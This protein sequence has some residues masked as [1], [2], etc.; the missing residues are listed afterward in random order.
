M[1][2]QLG[3]SR[4]KDGN[5]VACEFTSSAGRQDS[6]PGLLAHRWREFFAGPRLQP[7]PALAILV[8]ASLGLWGV[9]I[10]A[11]YYILHH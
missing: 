2:Q 7:G 3:S 9:I 1:A 10:W 5:G 11:L 4:K 8:L 6:A